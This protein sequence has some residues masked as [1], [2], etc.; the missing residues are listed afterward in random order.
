[1]RVSFDSFVF[2]S[3]ARQVIREGA[4]VAITPK[5]FQLLDLL[6]HHR[7]RAV[8][9]AEIHEA[10][11]PKSFASDAS[12]SNLVAELRAA[13]GDDAH[14]PRFLR[15]VRRFGYA[16]TGDAAASESSRTARQPPRLIWETREIQLA[17]GETLLGRDEDVRIWIDDA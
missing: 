2:D 5:A 12:L 16:F 13:L 3:D 4:P 9:K 15:T 17:P 6:I 8:S 14:A 1:M 7:T 11:W 10:L